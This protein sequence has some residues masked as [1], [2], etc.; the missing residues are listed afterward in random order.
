MK[1]LIFDCD[2]VLA[3]TERDGHRVAYNMA[4][5]EMGINAHWSLEEYG[6]LLR[7]TGGKERMKHFFSENPSDFP[8]KKFDDQYIQ[9]I[10]NCKT[11]IYINMISENKL[12]L[13]PG[14]E[15]LI[16]EA[17]DKDVQ[18]FVCSTSHQDS[19]LKLLEMNL[20]QEGIDYF[21]GIFCGDVV[22]RKKPSPDIY[23]L[24]KRK[25]GL[26]GE[27][28]LVI[29]DSR[30]GLLSAKAA[31]MRCIITP[32]FYNLD[33]DFKEADAIVSSLG[34]PGDTKINI[35][36][37]SKANLDTDYIK[38]EDLNMIIKALRD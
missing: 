5:E 7:F 36:K 16:K 11:K 29:E 25:F 13:K 23:N 15:R 37:R 18:L 1:A 34:D 38:L 21:T 28:C 14:I 10:H 9:E 3:E 2:G 30:A 22:K 17:Y 6:K 26:S 8:V 27:E 33:E 12:K 24:V 19:V 4:F 35:I 31:G 32:S 20:G